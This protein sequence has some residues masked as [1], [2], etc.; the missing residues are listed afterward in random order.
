LGSARYEMPFSAVNLTATR[1]EWPWRQHVGR[2]CWL[3]LRGRHRLSTRSRCAPM[4]SQLRLLRLLAPASL[5]AGA[6]AA[7]SARSQ[8][9]LQRER[10]QFIA[11]PDGAVDDHVRTR[12]P[13]PAL[14]RVAP[15]HA[16]ACLR[17]L[18]RPTAQPIALGRLSSLRPTGCTLPTSRPR[19]VADRGGSARRARARRRQRAHAPRHARRRRCARGHRES[20]FGSVLLGMPAGRSVYA[21]TGSSCSVTCGRVSFALRLHGP[22]ASYDTACSASLVANHGSVLALQP[23]SRRVRPP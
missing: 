22:C 9:L 19:R 16:E 21:S 17:G 3:R 7:A 6:S 2:A 1:F 4:R 20:E 13:A 18:P 15:R 8:I 11:Q 5:T 14:P 23:A 10:A 12:L